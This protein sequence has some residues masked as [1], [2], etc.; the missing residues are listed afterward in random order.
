MFKLSDMVEPFDTAYTSNTSYVI[1]DI[2][3]S[4]KTFLRKVSTM[5]K[6]LRKAKVPFRWDNRLRCFYTWKDA[7]TGYDYIMYIRI[8]EKDYSFGS[9]N[10]DDFYDTRAKSV[11]NAAKEWRNK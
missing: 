2:K 5:E 3:R 10:W 6:E 7:G 4:E 9:E 8:N 1:P 11:A